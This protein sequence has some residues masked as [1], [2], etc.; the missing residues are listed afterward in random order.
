M[1]LRRAIQT[2]TRQTAIQTPTR[3][4]V[5]G[6]IE[7]GDW[8]LVDMRTGQM[9]TAGSYTDTGEPVTAE[10]A[11]GY[12]AWYRAI[13]L[14][15]QKSAAVP[16]LLYRQSENRK[17]SEEDREHKVFSLIHRKA[18]TEQ[19]AFQFWLQMA[20][21][22]A[23]RGNGFAAIYRK[24]GAI[25]GT[26]EISELIPMDPDKTHPIRKDGKLWYVCFPFGE[27][28]QG[29][30]FRSEEVLH[31][32]GF[33]FDGLLGYPV[34]QIAANEI[35]LAR[36]E[37]RMQASRYRNSGR[38]SMILTSEGRLKPEAMNRLRSE[39]KSL[40]EG[41]DNAGKT[42]ILTDGLKATPVSMTA[43]EMEQSGASQMSIA[44][45]SN[46]TGVP[47]SKLGG[48]KTYAN[49]EQE[50]RAFIN[51]GLDFYLN[52]QDDE[53]AA[54]LLT[55]EEREEQEMFIRSDR[56]ALI[57]PDIKTKFDLLRIGTA[58]RAI[59]T[60]NEAREQIGYP[61]SDEKDAD[62]LLTPLN[63]GMGGKKNDPTNPADDGPGRP[64]ED[65]SD[66][67]SGGEDV[68]DDKLVAALAG[69]KEAARFALAHAATRMVKRIGQDAKRAAK[70]G[71]SFM[72]FISA[73]ETNRQV[74][75]SE[76]ASAERITAA[77]SEDNRPYKGEAADYLLLTLLNEWNSVAEQE[78]A[79]TLAARVE[80]LAS[81]QLARLPQQVVNIFIEE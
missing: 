19:T 6:S 59:L 53:A 67:K 65:G 4:P 23:S 45:I 7:G 21:H 1:F 31:F 42:I 56:E 47:V 76:F 18:N 48:N 33:G 34:W 79:K 46:Y 30:K 12:H 35:G 2:F 50:D 22:I 40:Y 5:A 20:G 70:S 77:I 72:A 9:L 17:G 73:I 63:M 71:N 57:R 13:S 41:I 49:V 29:F 44:A 15:A 54:K 81:D 55:D 51:D 78:S 64:A 80:S 37:R 58:G 68:D 27:Q 10:G 61:P 36:A 43:E 3:N 75:L 69:A 24:P 62:K 39:W 38:P 74:F 14:I 52:V 25:P 60:P 32:K 66:E 28:G 8:D 26:R 16:K 11:I